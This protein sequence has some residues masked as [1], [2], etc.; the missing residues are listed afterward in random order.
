LFADPSGDLIRQLTRIAD[1]LTRSQP[2]PWLEWT[3]NLF[4]FVAGTVTAFLSIEVQAR[5][6]DARERRKMR[7]IVYSELT[8][9]FALLYDLWVNVDAPSGAQPTQREGRNTS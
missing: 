9:S 7:R 2:S 1:A 8:N 3:R 5:L 4:S 6:G